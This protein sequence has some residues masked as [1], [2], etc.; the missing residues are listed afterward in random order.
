M[1]KLNLND[2]FNKELP[3]DAIKENHVRQVANAAFS[4]VAPKAPK[5]PSLIHV[6]PQMLEAVGLTEKD[7]KSEEFLKVFS[8][9][10]IY[11]GTKPFAM[12]YAGHQFGNWAGQL[13][14]GRAINLV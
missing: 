5:R 11:P 6:S 10:E 4:Y 9:A 13:G 3:A 14:D 7:A 8:G 1:M 12:A 2:T